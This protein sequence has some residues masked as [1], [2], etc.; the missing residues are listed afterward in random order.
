VGGLN[1]KKQI[2]LCHRNHDPAICSPHFQ[3]SSKDED[4]P[5]SNQKKPE[6]NVVIAAFMNQDASTPFDADI[7]KALSVAEKL[8]SLGYGFKLKD[9]CP[10]D[11]EHDTWAAIFTDE[12]G[13]IIREEHE[14]AATAICRAAFTILSKP[15]Q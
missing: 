8:Q 9:L 13:I 11:I 12:Q 2:F 3:L 4:Y 5:M 10:K 7:S 1:E 15:R 14:N 6:Q